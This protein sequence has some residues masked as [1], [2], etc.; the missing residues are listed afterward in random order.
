MA[1]V[2]LRLR[3]GA[4][5]HFYSSSTYML[6]NWLIDIGGISKALYFGGMIIAHFVALRAY[7][8]ALIGDSFM[9]QRHEPA[10]KRKQ[11]SGMF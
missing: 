8:A 2:E 7:E 5:A 11:R 9:V 6:T 1:P 4:K 3:L 10:M